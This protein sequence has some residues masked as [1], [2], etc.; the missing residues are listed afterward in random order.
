MGVDQGQWAL[1]DF[2]DAI[3]HIFN[4]PR[5]NDYDLERMWIE[6]PRLELEDKPAS[7]YGHFD[8]NDFER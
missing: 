2:G 3:L 4:G 6:A 5:R 7:L 8:M 1:I